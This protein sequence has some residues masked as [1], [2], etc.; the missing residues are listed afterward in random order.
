MTAEICVLNNVGVALAA[1]SAVTIG[2]NAEKIFTSAEKL[3]QLS[4]STPIGV[5]VYGNAHYLGVPWETIIKAYRKQLG[6]SSF[7]TARE[8]A[9]DLLAYLVNQQDLFTAER[10]DNEV[11][12]IL[13]VYC[14][15]LL[16]TI[17]TALDAIASETG[18]PIAEDQV[19]EVV[20]R[21]IR[22]ELSRTRTHPYLWGFGPSDARAI[23][24]RYRSHI[25]HV[26]NSQLDQLPL[27]RPAKRALTT[28]AI[29]ILVRSRLGPLQGG[30]VVAGFG[31]REYMPTIVKLAIEGAVLDR[32]R[33]TDLD[34]RTISDD[35]SALVV[36]FA[37]SDMVQM[38]M[39]GI[40]SRLL[41][42]M[43]GASR[44]L[45]QGVIDATA[46]VLAEI[47]TSLSTATREALES[48]LD[49]LLQSLR[50]SWLSSQ[51]SV[52][53]PV[54]HVVSSLPKDE[55]GA[56]AESLVNLTK[57]RRKITAVPETVGGPI[58]VAVITKGDGFVWL[59]RKHY[60]P[61]ELNPRQLARIHQEVQP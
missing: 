17:E 32:P 50:K 26:L 45:V 56:M 54:V 48:R 59:R 16:F 39:N 37:Q 3:F 25:R 19:P 53:G 49:P 22:D 27:T 30:V 11:D 4:V 23:R 9:E 21:V 8:Y 36:P 35:I 12:K 34:C 6:Q 18:S 40:D 55:L 44:D 33:R 20:E 52:W 51:C 1:D 5:M 15:H 7:A 14:S 41:E 47:D 2:R 10:H 46:D 42:D 57:F 29:E 13:A 24:K 31:E 28:C 60:F 38:F 58:D 61:A 43:H